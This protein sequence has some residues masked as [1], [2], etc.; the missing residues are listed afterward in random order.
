MHRLHFSVSISVQ[1]I[2]MVG[3][4]LIL[5]ININTFIIIILTLTKL[6]EMYSGLREKLIGRLFIYNFFIK[7]KNLPATRDHSHCLLRAQLESLSASD[8]SAWR[9]I[10]YLPRV[11]R[12]A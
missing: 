9:S 12:S 5:L 10:I 4:L 8:G 6:R 7:L 2:I 3:L 1:S 11:P